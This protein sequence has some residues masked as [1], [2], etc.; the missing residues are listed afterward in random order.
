MEPAFSSSKEGKSTCY[1]MGSKIGS[2]M[3]SEKELRSRK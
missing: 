3:I 1:L 2:E